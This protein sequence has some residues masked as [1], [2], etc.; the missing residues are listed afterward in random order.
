MRERATR[1]RVET[2]VA[3]SSDGYVL[4]VYKEISWSSHHAVDRVRRVLGTRKVGHA[5]TLDPLASGVLMI[6]VGRA[7]KLL[8]YLTDLPKTYRGT[9][10]L[11]VRTSSGDLGGEILEES[12]PPPTTLADVVR[13]TESFVGAYD[14]VP[15]MIS[16]VKHEG[17][18]LYQLAR[19][20]ME[21]EREPRRVHIYRFTVVDFEGPRIDFEVECSKGTYVRTL[22]EDLAA[23][24][25]T[26]ATVEWLARSAIGRFSI[27]DSVRLISRPG[28]TREGLRGSSV[29]MSEA[30]GHL[31]AFRVSGRGVDRIR[32]GEVPPRS[33]WEPNEVSRLSGT[34][35]PFRIL[36]PGDSLLAIG[37]SEWISGPSDR[38]AESNGV[39]QLER[40]F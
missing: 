6:G 35:G 39:V 27:D 3:E 20:G 1:R 13:A 30:L 11:G 9:I 17:K 23:S 16:A 7:T 2:L 14:Q 8:S 36:G 22:A 15:P 21:V 28:S 26:V 19:K 37:R 25:G 40:V 29:S 10:R 5:G 33:E 38:P 4:N 24:L 31:P 18:R 12:T 32:R 34:E